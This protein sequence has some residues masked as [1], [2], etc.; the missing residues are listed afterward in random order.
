MWVRVGVMGMV[1]TRNR[2]VIKGRYGT[3]GGRWVSVLQPGVKGRGWVSISFWARGQGC[4]GVDVYE[5]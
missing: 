2:V 5:Y 3:R 1:L 4:H